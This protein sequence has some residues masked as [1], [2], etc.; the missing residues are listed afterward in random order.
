MSTQ[1]SHYF[2]ESL[3]S[4]YRD[5]ETSNFPAKQINEVYQ[6]AGPYQQS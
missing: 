6:V 5:H 4:D 2:T 1:D 3:S